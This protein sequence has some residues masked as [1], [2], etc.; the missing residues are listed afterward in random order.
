MDVGFHDRAIDAHLFD[1]LLL[2]VA[3]QIAKDDFPALLGNGFDIRV[4][5]RFFESLIG[6]ADSAK[7]PQ[8]AGVENMKSQLF[9]SGLINLHPNCGVQLVGRQVVVRNM[10]MTE[11]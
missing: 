7:G 9:I 6:K 1:V 4:E 5:G 8:A 3:Q 2:G 10:L 11:S